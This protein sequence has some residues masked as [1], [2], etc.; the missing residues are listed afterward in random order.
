VSHLVEKLLKHDVP[1]AAVWIQDWVGLRKAFDG[2]RLKWNWQLDTN[3]YPNWKETVKYWGES[4]GIRVMTYINPFFSETDG[5][6]MSLGAR[7]LY[8]EGIT[9]SFFV[10]SPQ[11]GAYKMHSGSIEFCM[12]DTTNPSARLWMKDIMK[13]DMIEN[14]DS[15]GWMAD[16]GE[17]LPFDAVLYSKQNAAE[18]HNVYPEEWARINKEAVEEARKEKKSHLMLKRQLTNGI[19][20]VSNDQR[21][22]EN[23]LVSADRE[24]LYFMRAASLK[25]PAHTAL[26]WLGDQL[27]SWDKHDGLKSAIVGALSGGIG[28]HSITHSDIGG[29]TMVSTERRKHETT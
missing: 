11:G 10:Q 24:V 17:Y 7:N 4:H 14:S 25:S 19:A 3:Y 13:K 28:G 5:G 21:G 26:F 16:F 23:E 1:L 6:K 9:E 18:Y 29:Y 20:T 12:L 27:V 2:D 22:L 8:R 15:A